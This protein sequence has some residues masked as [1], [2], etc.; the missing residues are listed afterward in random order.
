MSKNI[1]LFKSYLDTDTPAY[2]GGKSKDEINFDGPIY[3][4]SSN[5]NPIGASPKAIAAMQAKINNL[6]MPFWEKD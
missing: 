2:K 5:E 3:K 6:F 4:L 1:S